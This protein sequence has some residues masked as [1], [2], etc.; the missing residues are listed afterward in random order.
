MS[1]TRALAL[2]FTSLLL[3]VTGLLATALAIAYWT[4]SG[5]AGHIPDGRRLVVIPIVLFTLSCACPVGLVGTR[6][7]G[8]AIL[9][10][11]VAVGIPVVLFFMVAVT[12]AY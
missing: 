4:E 8:V 5:G 9:L 6:N 2:S 1:T 3:L 11:L 10:V 12:F 7:T